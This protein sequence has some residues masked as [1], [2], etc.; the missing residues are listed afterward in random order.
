MMRAKGPE[1]S[2][3]VSD[4]VAVAG[5]PPGRYETAVGGT[6]EVCRQRPRVR[7][8]ARPISPARAIR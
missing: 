5:M 3:L 1:R 2:L 6:V 4:A 8:P 7:W